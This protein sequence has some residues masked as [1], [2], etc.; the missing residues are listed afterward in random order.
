MSD[1]ILIMA[2][3]TAAEILKGVIENKM[4]PKEA[5][6]KWPDYKNDPSLDVAFHLIYH[7][8]DD[9]DIRNK[10]AK[11]AE[12]QITQFQEIIKCFENGNELKNDLIKWGTPI[13]LKKNIKA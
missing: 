10:D 2:R 5:R 9:E 12:W 3:Q 13:Q 1:K 11:Y 6:S 4:T 8:E 7:F